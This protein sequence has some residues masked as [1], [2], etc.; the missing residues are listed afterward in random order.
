MIAHTELKHALMKPLFTSQPLFVVQVWF[1]VI[2]TPRMMMCTPRRR[3]CEND[4]TDRTNTNTNCS[5]KQTHTE[6]SENTSYVC[7]TLAKA[8]ACD[9]AQNSTNILEHISYLARWRF[10]LIQGRLYTSTQ[11]ILLGNHS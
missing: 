2:S 6:W 4:F 3:K 8:R 11:H 5:N 9:S 7:Q 1:S 10:S